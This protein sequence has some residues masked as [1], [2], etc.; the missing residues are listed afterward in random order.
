VSLA[1]VHRFRD[2]LHDRVFDTKEKI[3]RL[4]LANSAACLLPA[5]TV[6]F[7]RTASVGFSAILG[8]DMATTQDFVNW[9]CGPSL[10]P[11]YLLYC[12]RAM[13]SYLRALTMGSTHQTIYMPDVEGFTV[14]VP[15][16]SEQQAIAVHVLNRRDDLAK[17]VAAIREQINKLWAYRSA[18]ITG[19]VTGQLDIREHEKKMEALV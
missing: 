8:H 15:P 1:D 2:G 13:A 10:I 18:L 4:G 19:A 16:V 14:P 7:S 9:T 6:I 17:L 12:F 5:G 11:E 3:S